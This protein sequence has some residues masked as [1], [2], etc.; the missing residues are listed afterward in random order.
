MVHKC[1]KK[2]VLSHLEKDR[3]TWLKLSEHAK[4]EAVSDLKLIR[5]IRGM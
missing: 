3:K 5:A 1:D 4:E 2:K